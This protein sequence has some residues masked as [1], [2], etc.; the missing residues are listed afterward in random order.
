M[1]QRGTVCF[2]GR[3]DVFL[4]KR[5]VVFNVFGVNV[6]FKACFVQRYN[7]DGQTDYDEMAK[8]AASPLPTIFLTGEFA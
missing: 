3:A 2:L 5:V 7:R 1:S 6:Y 8:K 4:N